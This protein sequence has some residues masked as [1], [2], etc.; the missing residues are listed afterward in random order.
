MPS[1]Y[2]DI[3]EAIFGLLLCFGLTSSVALAAA[4]EN[5]LVIELKTGIVKIEMLPELAPKHVAAIKKLTRSGFYDGLVFHRVVE[6]FMAQTG[7]PTGTGTGGSGAKLRAEF[8][9][10]P[11]V[12][13]TVGMARSQSPHSASSQ[14]FIMFAPAP[15]LDGQYTVWGKVIEGMDHV[16][17]IKKGRRP[18]GTVTDPDKMLSVRILADM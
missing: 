14:F 5:I 9:R 16:D 11:F 10:E 6:G 8:S 15:H 3:T 2:K 18:D 13:G 4:P 17:Q 12:R 7:D 1:L